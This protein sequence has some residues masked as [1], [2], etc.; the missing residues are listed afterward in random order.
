MFSV[1]DKYFAFFKYLSISISLFSKDEIPEAGSSFNKAV[2]KYEI[3]L[4]FLLEIFS[5]SNNS[6]KFI[7]FAQVSAVYAGSISLWQ[8]S[9]NNQSFISSSVASKYAIEC[10]L[11]HPLTFLTIS[12]ISSFEFSSLAIISK[13]NKVNSSERAKV[14]IISIALTSFSTPINN[15]TAKE[16]FI[17]SLFLEIFNWEIVNSYKLLAFIFSLS[18]IIQFS[19]EVLD[20]TIKKSKWSKLFWASLNFP[21]EIWNT[22]F[23]KVCIFSSFVSVWYKKTPSIAPSAQGIPFS[24]SWGKAKS[25]GNF[26]HS[27]IEDFINSYIDKF[28]FSNFLFSFFSKFFVIINFFIRNTT[29]TTI[30]IFYHSFTEDKRASLICVKSSSVRLSYSLSSP[31]LCA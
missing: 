7:F 2:I 28:L 4:N 18:W 3:S 13:Q 14:F 23:F 19:K 12:K 8:P 6:S 20:E 16:N 17:L 5:S 24:S 30:S 25:S 11:P 31:F 29:T 1:E 15:N 21:S 26:P 9:S 22:I 27:R 10:T